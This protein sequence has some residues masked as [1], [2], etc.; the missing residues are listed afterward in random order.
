MMRILYT[1]LLWALIPV[2]GW[3]QILTASPVDFSMD[4][5]VTFTYNATLGNKAL[6]GH[7]G[8]VYIHTGVITKTSA[9]DSDWKYVQGTWGKPDDRLKMKVLAEGQYA[10]TFIPA[11][12]Y[13]LPANEE[14]K[15]LA[16]VFRNADGSLAGK[17]ADESDIYIAVSQIKE[18][19]IVLTERNYQSHELKGDELFITTDQ[20]TLLI[21]A[22]SP[23]IT[24][25]SLQSTFHQPNESS[26]SVVLEPK[27][28]Q[29]TVQEAGN[30]LLYDGPETDVYIQ[31]SPLR[32]K[33]IY[34]GD[35]IAK[36]EHGFY[37]AERAVGARFALEEG[38]AIYGGGSRAIASD[39]RGQ[40]LKLYNEAHY[41]YNAGAPVLNISIPFAL[42]EK[43]YGIFF[44]N[45]FGGEL[46]IASTDADVLDYKF[47]GG[48]ATYY[49]LSGEGYDQLL[50]RYTLLTGRQPLPP[51]WSL[52]FIQSKYGYET[53]EETREIVNKLQNED[54]PLDAVVLDL[55]WFGDKQKMGSLDWDRERFPDAEDMV[56]DFEE[57]GVK[58]ILIYEP[59]FTK[60]SGNWE[61]L[62]EKG[63]LVE[64][65]QGEPYVIEDFWTESPASLLK[66]SDPKAQQWMWQYYKKQIE[67]EAVHGWWNDLGE[68]ENH[69]AGMR[70]Y[71]GLLPYE[72]HN[73]YSLIWA[74]FIYENY[75]QDFP[76]IRVFNLIRSGFAGM[77][78]YATFPWSGDIQRSW[79]GY[80]PQVSIML[81]M[82]LNGVAYMHSDLG[83]FTGGEK[84]PELY[85]RWLQ[86]GAFNPI[87][88]AHGSGGVAPE[89]V[90]YDEPYKSIVRDYIKL[91]YSL[92]PYLYTMAW[93]NSRTGEPLA[94]PMNYYNPED[95]RLQGI[96]DQYFWGD[97]MLIAPVMKQGQTER[98]VVL[99]EGTWINY[100]TG[101]KHQGNQTV[102]VDAPLETMPIF[103]K[104]GAFLPMLPDYSSTAEWSTEKMTIRH[105]HDAAVTAPAY[106]LYLDNGTST[107]PEAHELISIEGKQG[108]KGLELMLQ[109][110]GSYEGMPEDRDITFEVVDVKPGKK[111]RWNGK[112]LK[113]VQSIS[114]L[115]EG[116][117]FYDPLTAT[118]HAKVEWEDGNNSCLLIQQ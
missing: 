102:A 4:D 115:E 23:G 1:T 117:A 112:K 68:P 98:E 110:K 77:Q 28:L 116:K 67:N 46:D 19:E 31:K 54:F 88:R 94:K 81:G 18:E 92:M 80:Q 24:K 76:E 71:G 61:E 56:K 10:I 91:R 36:E 21:Q 47:M 32:L 9:D 66:I 64:N 74:K 39:R 34:Q 37:E 55:F 85:T 109:R 14:V 86:F 13:D 22:V 35:T 42:S 96:D 73:V 79:E 78:R 11:E 53:E 69:P 84:Q 105:Y 29:V 49:V 70:H 63:L 57:E 72:I 33:Y 118:L 99:P 30:Y 60:A 95:E 90:N 101:E 7:D 106:Q 111:V 51:L 27:Q 75:Q 38:E 17:M 25:V 8:P 83:G 6:K 3:A 62:A 93:E 43:G 104:A 87:M 113:M 20:G 26:Y 16:F 48:P 45:H 103:I 89:P 41:G 65:E 59:Y 97:Y 44:D 100:H 114:E 40:K 108:E 82:G 15:K 2:A 5:E 50:E 12:F 58:T 52:G 107:D